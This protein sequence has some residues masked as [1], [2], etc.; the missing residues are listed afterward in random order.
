MASTAA[1]GHW[2]VEASGAGTRPVCRAHRKAVIGTRRR[3]G[4]ADEEPGHLVSRILVRRAG[5]TLLDQH[6]AY[7]SPEPGWDGPAVL[8][9]NRAVGQLLLVDPAWTPARSPS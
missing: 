6:T 4:R 3:Q 2:Q 1:R 8:N 9:G 7:G 5:R